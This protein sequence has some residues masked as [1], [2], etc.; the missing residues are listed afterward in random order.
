MKPLIFV[1]LLFASLT[2]A[3]E[4]AW[5]KNKADGK[6]ILTDEACIVDGKRYPHLFRSYMY[7]GDGYHVNSCYFFEGDKIHMVYEDGNEYLY[8]IKNFTLF[9]KGS[10]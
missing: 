7:T 8:P 5:I 1:L 4:M 10:V 3:E 6:I 9:K 2:N